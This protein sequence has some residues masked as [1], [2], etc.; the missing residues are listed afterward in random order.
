MFSDH[1]SLSCLTILGLGTGTVCGLNRVVD[2]NGSAV[3]QPEYSGTDNLV[4][5]ANTR[6]DRHLIAARALDS[7]NLLAHSAIGVSFRIFHL[8]DDAH[9]VAVGRIVNRGSRQRNYLARLSQRKFDLHEHSR[10]Q[11][12]P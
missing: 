7:D 1:A 5:R 9:R 10:T 4:S 3:A 11:F 6:N 12:V 8:S 2:L